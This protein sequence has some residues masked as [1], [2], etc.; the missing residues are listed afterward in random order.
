MS[1]FLGPIH[2]LMYDKIQVQDKL[3][4]FLV[5]KAGEKEAGFAEK[6]LEETFALPEGD[7]AEIVDL[8]NIHGS[9]QQMVE[10]VE[11][12]LA[13]CVDRILVHNVCTLE[14]LVQYAEEYGNLIGESNIAN[15][16]A[17][18]QYLFSKLLNGMPCDRVQEVLEKTD[19]SVV[20]REVR[21][22]HGEIWQEMKRDG[23]EFYRI[24][25]G[26][27]EGMLGKS[28]FVF[29]TFGPF[30]YKLRSAE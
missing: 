27:I 28:G 11:Y 2:Y 3:C 21:D 13:Y 19:N 9:L 1:A 26:M 30:H 10:M 20:W 25:S 8:N 15:A 16:V 14:E 23:S 22:I 29:E 7:L 18:Y 6:I 5:E 12:K 4:L 24:R 17:A